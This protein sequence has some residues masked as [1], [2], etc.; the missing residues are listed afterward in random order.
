MER[1]VKNQLKNVKILH[2]IFIYIL[3]GILWSFSQV[4]YS[5]SFL[6]W[7][8]FIP[9]LFLVK[10]EDYKFGFI[11]SLIFGISAYLFHLWWLPFPL[12]TIFSLGI[13]SIIIKFF[14]LILSAV[15]YILICFYHGLMY[16]F[17]FL[18]TKYISKHNTKLFYISMPLIITVLDYFYPKLFQDQIGY[19]QYLFFHF[20][21]IADLFGV[22]GITFLIMCCNSA[23]IIF[24]ESY[25]FKKKLN[26]SI[27]IFIIVILVVIGASLYGFFRYKYIQK[28]SNNT[29]T[30]KVGIIQGNYSGIDKLKNFNDDYIEND[31]ISEY[32]YMSKSLLKDNPDLIIWPETIIPEKNIN[33]VKYNDIKTFNDVYLLSGIHLSEINKKNKEYLVYNS[34]VLISDKGEKINQ[35]SKIKLLPFVERFPFF[36]SNKILNSLGFIEFSK[37]KENKIF[38]VNDIKIA[39]NICYEIII[40]SFIRK[41]MNIN[42]KEANLIVNITNDSWFGKTLEPKMHLRMAGIRA[43][44]NRKTLIRATCTGYSA[45]FNPAGDEIYKLELFVKDKIVK[46]VPLLEI[47]TVYRQFGWL[48]I[49]FL[50]AGLVFIVIFVYFRKISFK[51]YKSRLI[52]KR[53]HS[54]N[55]YRFWRD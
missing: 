5:F 11:Y 6:T 54:R 30:A 53:I 22:P 48:F 34:A 21:Q 7:F 31:I 29:K 16:A 15:I 9:Y 49:W 1:I 38:E 8:T 55:L 27:T 32:N 33:T 45:V 42:K 39:P 37:G 52:K 26:F 35:Y 20:S 51:F 19:S 4:G 25:F 41:S 17:A 43:I 14:F 3:F 28:I 40:P 46:D 13:K 10:Y 47:N 44:E 18:I 24:V 2:K 23:V 50:L 12:A 36:L